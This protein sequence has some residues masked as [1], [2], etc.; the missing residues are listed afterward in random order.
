MVRSKKLKILIL[1]G[2]RFIGFALLKKLSQLGHQVDILSKKK[3]N[4]KYFNNHFH[5]RIETM[6]N[7]KNHKYDVVFDFISTSQK[8]NKIISSIKFDKY[9]YISSIW[10]L[11]AKLKKKIELKNLKYESKKYILNKIKCEMKLRNLINKKL[12][13]LRLPIVLG[14]NDPTKRIENIH[15]FMKLNTSFLNLEKKK[16]INLIY[17]DDLIKAF[18]KMINYNFSNKSNLFYTCNDEFISLYDLV[19]KI[20]NLKFKKN[21]FSIK[22]NFKQNFFYNEKKI[23]FNKQK[24]ILN[25]LKINHKKPLK[26]IE[27][28][29]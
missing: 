5:Y 11:K 21:N 28:I 9:F 1:G 22:Y 29:L 4:K 3:I 8:I 7:L 2:T 12:I 25:I 13:I 17:I 16:N 20:Y 10:V 14:K 18:V 24:N 26:I 15:K 19:K 23:K 27:S 6:P